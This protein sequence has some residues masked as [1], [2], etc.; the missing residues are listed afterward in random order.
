MSIAVQKAGRR[1]SSRILRGSPLILH[2]RIFPG[3]HFQLPGP[4]YW[5]A[6]IPAGSGVNIL[7]CL[8]KSS[9][10]ANSDMSKSSSF[11]AIVSQASTEPSHAALTF[12]VGQQYVF[13]AVISRWGGGVAVW[14]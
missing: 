5:H 12:R 11:P 2:A 8:R 1:W 7:C 9:V 4:P 13:G 6:G 3:N 10:H 14:M